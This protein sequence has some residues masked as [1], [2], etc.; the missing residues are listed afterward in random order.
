MKIHSQLWKDWWVEAAE[1]SLIF[2]I[3]QAEW[4]VAS[5]LLLFHFAFIHCK[6]VLGFL[7]ADLICLAWRFKV[8]GRQINK[9][10]S[11]LFLEFPLCCAGCFIVCRFKLNRLSSFLHSSWGSESQVRVRWPF[12]RPSPQFSFHP[13][14][15]SSSFTFIFVVAQCHI[16]TKVAVKKTGDS[17]QRVWQ[18]QEEHNHS[19]RGACD[20]ESG[21]SLPSLS[22]WWHF[23]IFLVLPSETAENNCK[24]QGC[25]CRKTRERKKE[26]I[27]D[28]LRVQWWRRKWEWNVLDLNWL[29]LTWGVAVVLEPQVS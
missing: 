25:L 26:V 4:A 19:D 21:P 23:L 12:S 9:S 10:S 27:P 1:I 13:L 6:C 28:M 24:Q 17:E 3:L 16:D 8:G 14:H 5:P 7:R 20:A 18:G 22:L 11:L 15:S 2:L 29:D